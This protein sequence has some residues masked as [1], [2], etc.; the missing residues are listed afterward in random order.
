MADD[1]IKRGVTELEAHGFNVVVHPQCFA[2]HHRFAGT[3]IERAA[4]LMDM[5]E[6]PEI[7]GIMCTRGGSGCMRTEH[8]IDYDIIRYNPKFFCGYSD[9][10]LL[11]HAIE[12]ET[13]LTTFHG[14]MLTSFQESDEY[15]FNH[16]MAV[17]AGKQPEL[18]FPEAIPLAT[19]T[20]SGQLIGGS[21]SLLSTLLGTQHDFSTDN[22]LLFI[23]D[24]G[25]ELYKVDRL[26]WHLHRAG[27]LQNVKGVIV[28]E[29]TDINDS[30]DGTPPY[31]LHLHDVIQE[32]TEGRDLPIV[33]NAPC[34]HGKHMATFPLGAQA[35]LSVGTNKTTLTLDEKVTI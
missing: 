4:A 1:E 22:T 18:T 5:F 28:G 19:G 12:S 24:I 13:D 6:D 32:L 11:L 3:D 27:K 2:N 34:G 8:H 14:P 26:I 15:S 35:T 30:T 16:F 17:A 10:T 29:L 20:A 25:E 33:G 7:D 9:V 21:L 31:V 23:E